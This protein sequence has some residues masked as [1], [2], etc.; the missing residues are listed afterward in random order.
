MT[1]EAVTVTS[2]HL[3]GDQHALVIY[4]S[5]P[6]TLRHLAD[7]E[8]D[9]QFVGS[10]M[11]AAFEQKLVHATSRGSLPDMRDSYASSLR[12]RQP[13][14][15]ER[16]L[17]AEFE[18]EKAGSCAIRYQSDDE[19]FQDR[20]EDMAPVGC[21]DFCGLQLLENASKD[22]VPPESCFLNYLSVDAKFRRK[23][24]G[25]MLLNT[26]ETDAI[27]KG[28]PVMF[29]WVASSNKA[30]KFFEDQGYEVKDRETR[31]GCGLWCMTGIRELNRMEKRLGLSADEN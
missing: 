19:L 28:C 27:E 3:D 16:H 20:E 5:G 11:V 14:F 15:Y 24:I 17:I 7:T 12:G 13:I 4:K 21:T 31:C 29:L 26:A 8:D 18:G 30:K 10:M 9:R 23:G 25:K 2:P 1:N 22:E 6:V